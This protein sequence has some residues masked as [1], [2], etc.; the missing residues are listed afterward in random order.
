MAKCLAKLAM[1]LD[2]KKMATDKMIC[3]GDSLNKML[4]NVLF[5]FAFRNKT[6]RC[7]ADLWPSI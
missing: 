4:L 5:S 2:R 6:L 3:S 7:T 1:N